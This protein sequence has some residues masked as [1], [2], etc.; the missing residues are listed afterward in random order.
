MYIISESS[1]VSGSIPKITKKSAE[2]IRFEC[3]LQTV[4]DINRN[5]RRYMETVMKEGLGKVQQ[6]INEG[7]FIGELDHPTEVNNPM[8]QVTVLYKEASHRIMEC[9]W[10]GN[11]LIGV[12]ETLRTPN[13][14]ILKNLAED[15]LPV[16]FSFR[17]MGDLRQ[18]SENG[19]VVYNVESPLHVIT[20]DSVSFP[21]HSQATLIKITENVMSVIQEAVSFVEED[22]RICTSDGYCYFPNDFDK[23]VNRR[24]V[25]LT[26]KY[27]LK[28]EKDYGF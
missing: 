4:G 18:V 24:I 25:K 22:G 14:T 15:G 5:R 2:K 9:G 6:R 16:G 28:T 17:G 20:W 11:K 12:V 8:R 23:L 21:S 7:S 27:T 1:N 19:Q 26:E 13:G 3:C 10:D